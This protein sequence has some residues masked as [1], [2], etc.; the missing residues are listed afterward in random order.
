M[1]APFI[2]GHMMNMAAADRVRSARLENDLDFNTPGRSPRRN[3]GGPAV[4][5]RWDAF[6]GSL[7]NKGDAADAL[8]MRFRVALGQIGRPLTPKPSLSGLHDA[9]RSR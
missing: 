1:F 4:D 6:F 2:D 9:I 7:Q 5:P 8:G 3:I